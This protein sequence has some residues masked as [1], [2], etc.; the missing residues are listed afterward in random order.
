MEIRPID[1]QETIDAFLANRFPSSGQFLQSW[2]WGELQKIDGR[3]TWRLGIIDQGT[4]VASTLL[5][6]HPLPFEKSYLYCPKGPVMAE[7]RL[8]DPAFRNKAFL[9]LFEKIREI[10]NDERSLFIRFEPPTVGIVNGLAATSLPSV[11][12]E[13]IQSTATWVVDLRSSMEKLL[14]RSKSKTRYNIRL[15]E[16]RG[17]AVRWTASPNPN[18]L[19]AFTD[20]LLQTA[21]RHRFSLH[22]PRY[23]RLMA[24]VLGTSG[25]FMLAIAEYQKTIIAVHGLISF[26]TITTYVHGGSSSAYAPL[27]APHLLH[28][29]SMEFAKRSGSAF[30]DFGGVSRDQNPRHP[31]A[32]ISRFKQSFGGV[33]WE[34]PQALDILL[35]RGWY[36]GYRFLRSLRRRML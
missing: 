10:A 29:R 35:H 22:P 30:Y 17:V 26:G 6:R 31:W 34:S 16:K 2:T 23:Y 24:D 25:L 32:G 18:E 20:L 7:E 21:K 9:L 15:S 14:Q 13:S 4:L 5:I 1:D 36:R 19:D 8:T 28:W 3:K 27:M 11:P 12:T 33:L